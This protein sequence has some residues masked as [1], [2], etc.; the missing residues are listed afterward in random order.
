M[1]T[2][3]LIKHLYYTKTVNGELTIVGARYLTAG[4]VQVLINQVKIDKPPK[5]PTLLKGQFL[6]RVLKA[7]YKTYWYSKLI[8]QFFIVKNTDAA[9][10]VLITNI[11]TGKT[12][13]GGHYFDK[14][15]VEIIK[16]C[17]K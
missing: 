7:K 13:K 3:Q 1:T 10:Y 6:I 5:Y 9:V 17:K 11:Q 15:D 16:E 8:G 14:S 4:K 12:Y 2:I